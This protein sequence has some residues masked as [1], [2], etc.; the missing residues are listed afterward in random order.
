[1]DEHVIFVRFSR[2]YNFC[3]AGVWASY[4]ELPVYHWPGK[5]A[6]TS[7]YLSRSMDTSL[8][9]PHHPSATQRL[10]RAYSQQ[11]SEA[12]T[13]LPTT[14][15][16]CYASLPPTRHT[17]VYPSHESLLNPANIYPQGDYPS[18]CSELTTSP[19]PSRFSTPDKDRRRRVQHSQ[20]HGQLRESDVVDEGEDFTTVVS[21]PVPDMSSFY[22]IA[23][24]DSAAE[25][26]MQAMLP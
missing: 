20:P 21:I 19:G 1:M 14:A 10:V 3:F 13:V 15:N 23:P 18:F 8:L 2:I 25:A 26:E 7:Q 6:D 9:P 16:S 12:D 4:P 22:A 11:L 5:T 24:G 17:D